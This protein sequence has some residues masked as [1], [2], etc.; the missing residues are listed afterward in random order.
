MQVDV[1]NFQ[2]LA[3]HLVPQ[4]H[5]SF[6]TRPVH[7]SQRLLCDSMKHP[8]AS[9]FVHDHEPANGHS[10]GPLHFARI[11]KQSRMSPAQHDLVHDASQN[12]VTVFRLGILEVQQIQRRVHSLLLTQICPASTVHQHQTNEDHDQ[13]ENGRHL[14][15][16]RPFPQALEPLQR[17]DGCCVAAEKCGEKSFGYHRKDRQ[18]GSL[19]SDT[20]SVRADGNEPNT[21]F[22]PGQCPFVPVATAQIALRVRTP[23]QFKS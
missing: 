11:D 18:V 20:V 5:T 14:Q 3:I 10:C 17:K 8:M 22:G 21:S 2:P 1:Q 16:P 12:A 23:G 7:F 6:Q 4:K 19:T 9:M 15:N 13:V